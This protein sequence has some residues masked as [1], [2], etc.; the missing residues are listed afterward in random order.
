M[1]GNSLRA[2]LQYLRI[3]K[4]H[5]QLARAGHDARSLAQLDDAALAAL[6][7]PLGPRKKIRLN[8]GIILQSCE[9]AVGDVGPVAAEPSQQQPAPAA[10][11]AA[12][13]HGLHAGQQ[14]HQRGLGPTGAAGARAAADASSG[15]GSYAAG[16]AGAPPPP[17]AAGRPPPP[18]PLPCELWMGAL[19]AA[20]PAAPAHC[21]QQP[22]HSHRQGPPP[23]YPPNQQHQHQHQHQWGSGR[24]GHAPMPTTSAPHA[25]TAAPMAHARPH[26]QAQQ[27]A[28]GWDQPPH[29]QQ[30]QQ[31]QQH[32]HHHHH[33]QQQPQPTASC[34]Q[35]SSGMLAGTRPHSSG[36]SHPRAGPG[37]SASPPT[38]Q[39]GPTP[40]TSS[41][42][43]RPPA[44]NLAA[45]QAAAAAAAAAAFSLEAAASAS[46]GES[47]PGV[48]VPWP[49]SRS[50]SPSTSAGPGTCPAAADTN[51]LGSY[52]M[53]EAQGPRS[54]GIADA[55]TTMPAGAQAAASPPEPPS[56]LVLA[57]QRALTELYAYPCRNSPGGAPGRRQAGPHGRPGHGHVRGAVPPRDVPR[58]A[59]PPALLHASRGA[60]AP[61]LKR[62]RSWDGTCLVR[63]GAPT[64]AAV[65]LVGAWPDVG[66]GRLPEGQDLYA[67]A[68]SAGPVVVDFGPL[69][70]EAAEATVQA[71]QCLQQRQQLQE[72]RQ[73]HE[74]LL[75]VVLEGVASRAAPGDAVPA[76][77]RQTA[78][79][80]GAGPCSAGASAP[81]GR[82][83]QAP[84]GGTGAVAA[85][86]APPA[87]ASLLDDPRN[88][89]TPELLAL[90]LEEDRA[91]AEAADAA[92]AAALAAAEAAEVA[93]EQAGEGGG[94]P[95]AQ[96]T[97]E[98]RQARLR[99][100]RE[101]VAA[102]E[103]LLETLRAM[104]AEEERGLAAQPGGRGGGA[105]AATGRAGP[106]GAG[107]DAGAGAGR[108]GAVPGGELLQMGNG[109]GQPGPAP[110]FDAGSEAQLWQE[111]A[112][113][114]VWGVGDGMMLT[115]R[116]GL[117]GDL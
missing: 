113:T 117:L 112:Q 31:Q 82:P 109:R 3:D 107:G 23:P 9:S 84:G 19:T 25:P 45:P 26:E 42:G 69:K 29:Q 91:A 41:W 108:T 18:A 21:I 40:A 43:S 4:Y 63:T 70:M 100:L 76:R 99:A 17:G 81:H 28:S 35:A 88:Y 79:P 102:T 83:Q 32:H 60:A 86:A 73:Q 68:A 89:E 38:A 75:H 16:A 65:S 2:W 15:G 13:D 1:A 66:T 47:R 6:G 62:S 8:A 97:R 93:G 106:G 44:P 51:G 95:G 92:A 12:P 33:H 101:E 37:G 11:P 34:P 103:R 24:Q 54:M 80:A 10:G 46:G 111:D 39:A 27:Q 110:A 61:V 90:L 85:A 72:Q 7:L 64:P 49:P 30:Q 67:A 114:Q 14:H 104:V 77:T 115:E 71:R 78:S 55:T 96:P 20:R 52:G 58:P 56:A 53:A 5:D 98:Q 36:S 50:A 57:E 105:C 74:Q 59:R 116:L 22:G 87:G 48:H 94:A